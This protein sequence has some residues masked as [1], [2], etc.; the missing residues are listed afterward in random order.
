[1]LSSGKTDD[2]LTVTAAASINDLAK[3]F[4]KGINTIEIACGSGA[5]RL[6]SEVVVNIQF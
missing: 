2:E 4:K 5:A 3:R 6:G 1:V